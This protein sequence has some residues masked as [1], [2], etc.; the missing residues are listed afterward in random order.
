LLHEAEAAGLLTCRG[1]GAGELRVYGSVI[2][3]LDELASRWPDLLSGLPAPVR[4]ELERVLAGGA[5]SAPQRLLVAARELVGVGGRAGGLVVAVED[6]HLIDRG[7]LE[8]LRHLVRGIRGRPV[9]LVVTHPSGHDLGS[10]FEPI[11][12]ADDVPG[13]DD[14]PVEVRAALERIAVLGESTTVE[15]ALAA[16]GLDAGPAQRVLDVA[17]AAGF[18]ARVSDS[19]RFTDPT[20]AE[21]L[22]ASV[23]EAERRRVRR[24]AADRLVAA[25]A[26]PA[27]IA[28]HL[29][30][31]GDRREAAP[32]QV[33]A[34][35]AAAQLQLHEEVLARTSDI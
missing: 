25:G 31:A 13:T 22:A 6:A 15:E 30:A 35:A 1:Q 2:E 5:P 17:A 11:Q 34:A 23:G 14:V 26:D 12:L 24:R 16:T 18:L 20:V 33:R 29:L 21:S 19:L 9:L 4:T 27:R 3:A 10:G 32:H 28:D 7:T 8:L